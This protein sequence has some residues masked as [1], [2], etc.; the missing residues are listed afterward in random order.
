MVLLELPLTGPEA[1]R[2]R[3]LRRFDGA[4]EH[5]RISVSTGSGL[6]YVG[7]VH[8]LLEVD[9]RDSSLRELA[10]GGPDETT[11]NFVATMGPVRIEGRDHFVVFGPARRTV[12]TSMMGLQEFF[13]YLAFIEEDRL[14]AR[15]PRL[16]TEVDDVRLPETVFMGLWSEG[17][18]ALTRQ[19]AVTYEASTNRFRSSARLHTRHAAL[20]G[21]ELVALDGPR[22]RLAVLPVR[23]LDA[24]IEGRVSPP[25]AGGAGR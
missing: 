15:G 23:G 20:N 7:A 1:G 10:Y 2:C 6:L 18:F 11:W 19:N 17:F 12:S 16:C 13:G 4:S 8:R 21:G 24:L 14:V 9:P 3:V 5:V 25:K 22:G